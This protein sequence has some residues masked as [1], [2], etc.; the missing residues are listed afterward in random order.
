[1]LDSVPIVC[2]TGQVF[3]NLLGSD[4][5][6]ETDVLGVVTGITKDDRDMETF[7]RTFLDVEHLPMPERGFVAA[8]APR[9]IVAAAVSSVFAL[10][11]EQLGLEQAA[12]LV[13]ITFIVIIGT[14]TLYA[15]FT[16]TIA[17]RLVDEGKEF[18]F[19]IS[20]TTRPPREGER[21]GVDY[22]FTDEDG[23]RGMVAR[24]ELAEWAEVHGRLYG[25]PV[26]NLEEAAEGGL[27]PLLD[28][29]VQGARQIRERVPDALLVFVLPPSGRVWLQRLRGRG[30]EGSAELRRR[31][32]T[33]VAELD[34]VDGFDVVVV[35]D[36]L[37]QAVDRV[38]TVV[39]EGA[40]GIGPEE[41]VW[42]VQELRSGLAR[43]MEELD[44][45]PEGAGGARRPA[46][47]DD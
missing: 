43:A 6:Q 5:F 20:A 35:N 32:E 31:L 8:L 45:V 22:L 40:A 12:M 1:M 33:A 47:L 37:D 9:G 28:I 11:L 44:P 2:I 15:L 14:V 24:G 13:P 30:T 36:D 26:R 17:R 25:T 27:F 7:V 16:P 39:L 29:D 42:R 19:S 23:F 3:K 4:A 41:V 21:T 18:V 46:V 34:A 10:R 38:R